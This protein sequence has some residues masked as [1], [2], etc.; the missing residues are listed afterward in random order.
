MRYFRDGDPVPGSD[1]VAN[2][3]YDTSLVLERTGMPDED[4]ERIA[5]LIEHHLLMTNISQYRDVDDEDIVRN[6]AETM[7]TEQR[8]RALF[9][10]S[11]ADL[12]AVGP[13]VWNDWK[14]TL[15]HTQLLRAKSAIPYS[16][17]E[18]MS[19]GVE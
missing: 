4:L 15:L 11:Y 10:M 17:R 5:F 6:F 9:L 13:G 8:L 3:S 14:G 12:S 7:K 1:A 2:A 16:M 18:I 19:A